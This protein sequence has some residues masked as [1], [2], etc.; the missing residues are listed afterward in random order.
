MERE[1]AH[2]E[3][4]AFNQSM[5]ECQSDMRHVSPDGYNKQTD[6]KY[7]TYDKLDKALR[8]I[9]TKHG[10]GLSFDTADCDRD[11][12]VR[13]VCHVTHTDGHCH[14]YH[15]DMPADGKGAKGG[16]VMTTTHATGAAATYGMRYLLK[17]IFNVA[18]G[19]DD[20]DGNLGDPP[21]VITSIELDNLIQLIEDAGAEKAKI[22]EWAEVGDLRD[23]SQD[24]YAKVVQSL[25]KR[26]NK[27]GG[28]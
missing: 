7:A 2:Q 8:P 23:M 27:N 25:T 15:I 18:I 11:Q 4:R 14:D 6:S 1:R 22:C 24:K 20:S 28:Q 3:K 16:A 10:F 26:I 21:T 17:M 12:T 5:A 9:Y 13:V 19:E